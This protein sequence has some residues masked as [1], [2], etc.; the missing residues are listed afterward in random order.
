MPFAVEDFHDLVGLLEQHPHW[1]AELRRL[2]LSDELLELPTLARRL[3]E[4][5]QRTEGQLAALTGRVAALAEAQQR[6]EARVAALAEAQQRTEARVAE[7]AE[8]QARTERQ[9]AALTGRVDALAEAQQRTEARVAELAEAQARTE[10]QLAA[11]TGRVDA[12]V[13]AQTWTDGRLDRIEAALERLTQAQV[14]TEERL[15]ALIGRFDEHERRNA[16]DFQGLKDGQLT[17]LLTTTPRLLRPLVDQP[18]LLGSDEVEALVDRL[19]AQG[20]LERA[21]AQDLALIDLLVRGRRD[22]EEG[23]LAV[24]ASWTIGLRDIER[25]SRRAGLLEQAGVRAWPAVVGYRVS[26]ESQQRLLGG[27][28]LS[29]LLA[30]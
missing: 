18:R 2:V 7:L 5:Q 3:A 15:L 4:A 1:R 20:R 26:E 28:V 24:E 30:E 25:A 6:T 22:G 13:E 12:L 8:A 11:L 10:G 23:Y 19:V 29:L 14:S 9:L 21:E 16:L 17:G 27:P